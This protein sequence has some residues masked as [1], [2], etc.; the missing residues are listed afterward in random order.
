[1]NTESPLYR[2]R[3]ECPVC[4]NENDFEAVKVGSYTES[5]RD[6]DFRP[7]GRTWRHPE[8]QNT[9][10][11][12]Y[13]VATCTSCHYT[14]ELDGNYRNWQKDKRFTLYRQK[15]LREAHLKSLAEPGGALRALGSHLDLAA[16]PRA[17]TINK[18]LLG[19]LDEQIVEGGDRLNVA[20]FYLR[21]AWLFRDLGLVQPSEDPRL[22][23]TADVLSQIRNLRTLLDSAH[24]QARHL[25]LALGELCGP[26]GGFESQLD[27]WARTGTGLLADWQAAAGEKVGPQALGPPTVTAAETFLEFANHTAFLKQVKSTWQD[28]PLSEHEA[29]ELALHHYKEYFEHSRTFT[30]PEL[31]VQTAYLI[32]EIAR[33]VGRTRDASGYFNHAIRKGHELIHEYQ[34]DPQRS[35]YLR[36]LVDMSVE[37][38]KKN[39]DEQAVEVQV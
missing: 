19:I 8:F 32:A 22:Q 7:T 6:S 31:E 21:M 20:R 24:A 12:Y 38:G 5:G 25:A 27:G 9:D 15:A 35:G 30:S 3:I 16:H 28:V 29:L 1:M 33:R 14:R 2:V 18:L 26:D 4:R 13:S 17:T 34:D 37:Q 39:R 36:K 10:P 11:L 23:Q